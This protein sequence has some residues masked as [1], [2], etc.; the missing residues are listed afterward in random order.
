M[1]ELNQIEMLIEM[2][3][4]SETINDAK[5][6]E[7]DMQLKNLNTDF[8]TSGID[9]S[10]AG[11]SEL[12]LNALKLNST[13]DKGKVIIPYN[14]QTDVDLSN[15]M[16]ELNQI[17]MLIEISEDSETI[18]DAKLIEVDMQLKNLNTDFKTSWN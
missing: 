5:L 6:I 10:S 18:N 13:Q 12:R 1:F 14:D 9:T 8:K 7:V 2:S 3:E 11:Q 4:D 15:F 16:F 17:E